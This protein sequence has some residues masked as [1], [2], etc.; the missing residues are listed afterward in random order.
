MGLVSGSPKLRREIGQKREIRPFVAVAQSQAPDAKPR[1]NLGFS[2]GRGRAENGLDD[3]DWSSGGNRVSNILC[4][5]VVDA[6]E[7]AALSIR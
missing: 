1:P 4:T 2:M 5:V 3:G 6:L 7:Q